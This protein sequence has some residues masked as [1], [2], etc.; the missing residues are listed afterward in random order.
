MHFNTIFINKIIIYNSVTHLTFY[1]NLNSWNILAGLFKYVEA[2][3][4]SAFIYFVY[5]I[6]II[7]LRIFGLHIELYFSGRKNNFLTHKLQIV[8]KYTN[9]HRILFLFGDK[10]IAIITK[11]ISSTFH[12]LYS[13]IINYNTIL[14]IFNILVFF[15]GQAK[16]ILHHTCINTS[17]L[18][19][20]LDI[21]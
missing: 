12:I 11:R 18:T 10:K 19:I 14:Y 7:R 20:L 4:E 1:L 2:K 6:S 21:W 9:T 5:I 17:T 13:G 15:K 8:Y 3:T 16:C